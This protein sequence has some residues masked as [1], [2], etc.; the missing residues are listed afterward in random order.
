MRQGAGLAAGRGRQMR[1]DLVALLAR[2]E[3]LSVALL[4]ARQTSN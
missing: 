1:G 4:H 2:T 3:A